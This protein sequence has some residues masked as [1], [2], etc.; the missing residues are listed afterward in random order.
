[1]SRPL[2]KFAGFINEGG[3]S[4]ID[5]T[6]IQL[7]F[8]SA[9]NTPNIGGSLKL[10]FDLVEIEM[11]SDH[12][13][14]KF[15]PGYKPL[16]FK[17]G[18]A[19]KLKTIIAMPLSPCEQ[20]HLVSEKD[21]SKAPVGMNSS[22]LFATKDG[23]TCV[24][25]NAFCFVGSGQDSSSAQI[26]LNFAFC[27][28]TS[29]YQSFATDSGY[30]EIVNG[31]FD[32]GGKPLAG[33]PANGNGDKAV[34]PDGGNTSTTG[35]PTFGGTGSG[36]GEMLIVTPGE[37]ETGSGLFTAVEKF[38]D[39]LRKGYPKTG[40]YKTPIDPTG[41]RIYNDTWVDK[42]SPYVA[43]SSGGKMNYY[44]K[45]NSGSGG[46][47]S[48]PDATYSSWGAPSLSFSPYATYSP[49]LKYS[50]PPKNLERE[51]TGTVTFDTSG[52]AS[53]AD[54][55]EGLLRHI[56]AFAA[57]KKD[58]SI[59]SRTGTVGELVMTAGCKD[60]I[61]YFLVNRFRMMGLSQRDVDT[62]LKTKLAMG[63]SM[64]CWT[65]NSGAGSGSA[66]TGDA[67]SSAANKLI[68]TKYLMGQNPQGGQPKVMLG[69]ITNF[70]D[71]RRL[72]VGS[73]SEFVFSFC[74]LKDLANCDGDNN[75][76]GPLFN[77]A[78]DPTNFAVGKTHV[79]VGIGN[80]SNNN[81]AQI[82]IWEEVTPRDA[83]GNFA[84]PN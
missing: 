11:P 76:S 71:K 10:D 22:Q 40:N 7:P 29:M 68:I 28:A 49:L 34:Q 39:R 67:A 21:F 58:P 77:T 25:P 19:D 4:N 56:K 79:S 1:L 83:S 47:A 23:L 72:P 8:I 53:G 17:G 78:P 84:N 62:V 18:A 54:V 63:E 33:Y 46:S 3:P 31:G 5:Y 45:P 52:G 50:A 64:M 15:V 37:H 2:S 30:I 69:D 61:K 44:Y 75:V 48:N 32:S 80:A 12:K 43:N 16:R 38:K 14:H 81:L 82:R 24:P 9:K 6:D 36:G 70:Q 60:Q 74:S 73:Q 35:T 13:K 27:A 59:V 42:I 41:V 57:E 51:G 26:L 66:A 20:P 65:D 55:V